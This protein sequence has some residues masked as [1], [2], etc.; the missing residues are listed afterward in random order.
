METSATLLERLANA[1]TDDDWRRLDDLYRPLLRAW[2]ARAGG[3]GRQARRGRAGPTSHRSA[4][5]RR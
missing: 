2:M 4:R 3:G 1:P 5:A